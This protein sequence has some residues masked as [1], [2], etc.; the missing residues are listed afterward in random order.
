V[1]WATGRLHEDKIRIDNKEKYTILFMGRPHDNLMI[2]SLSIAE[3]PLSVGIFKNQ[4]LEL[5]R[6]LSGISWLAVR[7]LAFNK[8]FGVLSTFTDTAGRPTLKDY[9]DTPGVYSAGRLDF[10]SEGL[11]LLSDDGEFI[12]LLTDPNFHLPKTY[13]VQVEG[14]VTAEALAKL[15]GGVVIQGR[16]TQRCQ[17][18]QV[19]DPDLALRDKPITPHGLVSWLRIVL[20]EGKKR[21]IRHMT[22]AVGLFSLRILRV[23]IGSLTLQDLAPGQWREMSQA[24][25]EMLR[26]KK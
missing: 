10:D 5:T 18:M 17:V 4:V 13:L 16:R 20:R 23:A 12:H 26:R 11:L 6:L 3:N 19:P 15:K 25:V 9:I 21:Q 22:A 14:V 1:G 24:E 7:Y 2:I 8:P